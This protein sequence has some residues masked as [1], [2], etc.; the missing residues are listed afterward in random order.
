MN[1]AGVSYD[2]APV[3]VYGQYA[4]VKNENTVT[5]NNTTLG[6]SQRHATS[7]GA[8]YNIGDSYFFAQ[9]SNGK[10]QITGT[11]TAAPYQGDWKGHS[12]GYKHALSK[13]TLAYVGAG[14]A[15]YGTAA[16]A[17]STVKETAFGLLHAF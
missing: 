2:L 10:N 13:R 3:K 6:N 7:I 12:F 4:S 17:K 8:R 11:A 1:V 5:S 14:K 16:G 15:E 9:V